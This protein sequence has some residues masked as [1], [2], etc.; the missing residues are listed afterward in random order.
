MLSLDSKIKEKLTSNKGLFHSIQLKQQ[1]RYNNKQNL[2]PTNSSNMSVSSPMW[3]IKFFFFFGFWPEVQ[4]I[5]SSQLLGPL[6]PPF[7]N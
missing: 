4:S 6:Q 1:K 2:W 3:Y 5:L 7:F